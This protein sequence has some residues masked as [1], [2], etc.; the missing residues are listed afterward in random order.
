MAT[1]Y[2]TSDAAGGGDGSSGDPWTLDEATY[3]WVAP[4][5]YPGDGGTYDGGV[6]QY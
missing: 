5:P 3:S 6:E 2:V 4:I 1:Y